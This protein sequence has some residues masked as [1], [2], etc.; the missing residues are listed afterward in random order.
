MVAELSNETPCSSPLEKVRYWIFQIGIYSG[1]QT[2]DLFAV[3][4]L[5]ENLQRRLAK[6]ERIEQKTACILAMITMTQDNNS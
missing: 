1:S 4:K 6:K 5:K 2:D 3:V